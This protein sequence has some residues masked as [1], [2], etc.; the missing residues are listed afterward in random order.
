M[1]RKYVFS[2]QSIDKSIRLDTFLAANELFSSRSQVQNLIKKQ[3]IFVNGKNAKGSLLLKNDDEITVILSE[4]FSLIIEPENIPVKIEYEDENML[5]VNK[6]KEMLTHPTAKETT[7]TLVNALLYKY[8]YE[9]LSDINGVMRPGIVHRLDRN[10]SGLLMVAKNNKVHEFIAEQIK[11][12]TAKRQYIA[13]VHGNFEKEEGTVDLPIGRNPAKPE[14]MAV[15][16]GGKPSVTHYKVLE[17]FKDF[18][19]V[20]LTLETGRT[21]QIRVHMNHIGHPIVN[22]SL[23]NKTKF[24]VKTTEQV[25]QAYKLQFATINNDDIIKLEI[26]PDEDIKKVLKFLRSNKQ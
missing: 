8:G 23:Y 20:E 18:S 14:K 17:T 10:T 9:G 25:L 3:Q 11:T 5:V 15:I 6:P 19:F 1:N 22:D 24:K 4:D 16:E 21:H 13:V 7:G 2:V 26:E 12:K